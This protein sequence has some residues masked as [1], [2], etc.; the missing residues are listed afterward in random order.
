MNR[1]YVGTLY[2]RR[3]APT[4][5]AFQYSVFLPYLNLSRIDESLRHL[6]FWGT[7][8]FNL[9]RFSRSDFM[10]PHD[11]DLS[12]LIKDKVHQELGTRPNGDVY[13]LANLRYFGYSINPIACYFCFDRSEELQAI[14]LEVTNTPWEERIA[15]V[16]PCT[17]RGADF[18][19][20]KGMHVSPFNP[21]DMTYH[22]VCNSP[23]DDLS[24][25]LQVQQASSVIFSA[26]LNLKAEPLTPRSAA[27]ILW[28]HPH[29]TLK[30]AAGIYW[31]AL[32]LWLKKTPIYAHPSKEQAL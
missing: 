27:T 19:F 29:M 16:V 26:S 23:D 31:Q 4:T 8:R 10:A 17:N 14:V 12:T 3:Q 22:F 20:R 13:L 28:R 24:I 5:H 7:S 30:V 32:K 21:M 1:L 25:Q 11:Q 2:H 18:R 15:Y 9:A 6:P